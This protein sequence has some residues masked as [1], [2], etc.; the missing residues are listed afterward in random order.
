MMPLPRCKQCGEELSFRQAQSHAFVPTNSE[1]RI[2]CW[3]CELQQVSDS[4]ARLQSVAAA[5]YNAL[6]DPEEKDTCHDC[7]KKSYERYMN[8]N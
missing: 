1:Q 4:H 6:N 8:G 7:V 3:G 5:L 2:I